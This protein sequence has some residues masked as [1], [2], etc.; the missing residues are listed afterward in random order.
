MIS[1]AKL[2]LVAVAA[3]AAAGGL[4]PLCGAECVRWRLSSLWRP[5]RP[6]RRW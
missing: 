5:K 4:C 2:A 6:T 3:L 1:Q